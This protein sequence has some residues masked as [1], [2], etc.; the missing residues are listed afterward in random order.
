MKKKSFVIKKDGKYLMD[1]DSSDLDYSS[2]IY[3]ADIVE[4]E[5]EAEGVVACG[6]IE[7]VVGEIVVPITIEIKEI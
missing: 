3:D 6:K 2:N 4:T 7:G 5:E 1:R